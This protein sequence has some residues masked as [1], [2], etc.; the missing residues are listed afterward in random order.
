[1][2]AR[3]KAEII[4]A[5]N[6]EDIEVTEGYPVEMHKMYIAWFLWGF[7]TKCVF[8]VLIGIASGLYFCA[9]NASM[10]MGSISCGLYIANSIV[11]LLCGGIWR[12]S[13]AGVIAAGDKLERK[14]GVSDDDWAS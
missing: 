13:K 2:T 7:F 1:V 4:D 10:I 8:I 5:A 6:K 11:W 9:E 14:G 3:T 12:F